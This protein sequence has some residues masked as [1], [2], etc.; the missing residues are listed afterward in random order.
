MK[1]DKFFEN[2][3][4]KRMQDSPQSWLIFIFKRIFDC[5][6]KASQ[7]NQDKYEVQ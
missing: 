5:Y 2:T 7:K 3:L 6:L 4:T 1:V